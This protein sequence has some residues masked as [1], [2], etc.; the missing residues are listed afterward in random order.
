MSFVF[1]FFQ[2]FIRTSTYIT[3]WFHITLLLVI[4]SPLYRH[5]A[6]GTAIAKPY[7]VIFLDRSAMTPDVFDV[8]L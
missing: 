1:F 3:I 6:A 2:L 5:A 8:F 7:H 4:P